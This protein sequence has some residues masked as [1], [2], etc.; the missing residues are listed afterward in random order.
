MADEIKTY[1]CRRS[2]C[3]KSFETIS[4]RVKHEKKCTFPAAPEIVN[5]EKV[6]ATKMK[7]LRCNKILS[8]HNNYYRHKKLIHETSVAKV[9]KAKVFTCK[10][11]L[12]V[13]PKMQHEI[14]H[15]FYLY[16]LW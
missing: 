12:K 3:R 7:C 14:V 6:D 8:C 15:N 5:Y 11:C 2:G 4:G 1:Q 13:F 10:I 9:R 16:S